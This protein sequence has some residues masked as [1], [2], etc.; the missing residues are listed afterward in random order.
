MSFDYNINNYTKEDL[1]DIFELPPNYDIS[2]IHN[3]ETK[4]RETIL[5]NKDISKEKQRST[6]NFLLEAK[7]LLLNNPNPL[8]GLDIN[9]SKLNP[10]NT[11]E[12][13]VK[14]IDDNM[15]QLYHLNS[16]LVSTELEGNDSHMVQKSG[17]MPFLNVS[18]KDFKP[19]VMN[20]LSNRPTIIKNL[21]IDTRFRENYY[22]TLSTNFNFNLPLTFNNVVRMEL[23]AI[24]IPESIY[25]ISKQYN[26]NYFTIIVNGVS[27]VVTISDGT[28]SNVSISTCIN[29]SLKNLGGDFQY[30]Q[31]ITNISNNSITDFGELTGSGQII[32]NVTNAGLNIVNSLTLNF[33]ADRNGL[34]DRNTPLPLKLGWVLGFRNGIYTNN[35]NYV[36]EGL[37][38]VLG[39]KY[40]FLVVDDYNNNVNNGFYSAFN[41]SMLNKNILARISFNVPNTLNGSSSFAVKPSTALNVLTSVREYFGPVNIQNLNIQLLDQYGRIVN[42]NNMDFSFCLTLQT[43]YD[44]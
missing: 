17:T 29:N 35:L 12:K 21:N 30:I 26:N 44:V 42:L 9:M 4:L 7:Q 3:K 40:Y 15:N 6:L 18:I 23:T 37:V 11:L 39:P 1:M 22:T 31:F 2:M 38:D 32:V 24:E 16:K 27:A 13:E 43:V 14:M 33:Q 19:G 34:D 5:K 8:A 36:S 25:T 10:F 41:S 28:Y 20:P